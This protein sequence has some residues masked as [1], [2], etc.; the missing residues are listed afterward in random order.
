MNALLF[1][2]WAGAALGLGGAFLLACHGKHSRYGWWLFLAANFAM[3]G[4]ALG[5]DRYG[6]LAQQVGFVGT[7]ALGLVRAGFFKRRAIDERGN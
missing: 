5:L 2:E 4:L 6:L 1:L 3:I 7:S